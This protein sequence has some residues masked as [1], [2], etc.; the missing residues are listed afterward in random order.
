[1]FGQMGTICAWLT[2]S[3]KQK[4][5]PSVSQHFTSESLEFVWP[6][7]VKLRT[8]PERPELFA[9]LLVSEGNQGF[10]RRQLITMRW[11]FVEA[12]ELRPIDGWGAGTEH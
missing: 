10:T 8:N 12:N 4:T 2:R 11:E 9:H 7:E 1:M 5:S 6:A 3:V